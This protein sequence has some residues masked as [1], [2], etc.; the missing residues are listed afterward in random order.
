MSFCMLASDMTRTLNLIVDI[1]FPLPQSNR[2]VRSTIFM[3]YKWLNHTQIFSKTCHTL[4]QNTD[5][6]LRLNSDN[7]TWNWFGLGFLLT[8]FCRLLRSTP[9]LFLMFL[10]QTHLVTTKSTHWWLTNWTSLSCCW[11]CVCVCVCV[12][13]CERE[14]LCH[15]VYFF[16]NGLSWHAAITVLGTITRCNRCWA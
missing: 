11:H 9:F 2:D 15:S 1:C 16:W 12:C 13:V 14:Q 7:F 10:F 3:P 4:K 6:D 5:T 8:W